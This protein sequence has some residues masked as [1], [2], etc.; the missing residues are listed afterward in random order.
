M[1]FGFLALQARQGYVDQLRAHGRFQPT[2]ATIVRSKLECSLGAQSSIPGASPGV[3]CG[4]LVQYR[5]EI[6]GQTHLSTRIAFV[7]HNESPDRILSRYP[8]GARVTAFVDPK[9]PNRA[10]LDNTAWSAM[11]V[12][13]LFLPF[14]LV[15]LG[16]IWVRQRLRAYVKKRTATV[17]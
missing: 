16:W 1:L 5:Y 6:D 15:G 13:R 8:L 10:V 7:A 14:L 2:G 9:D 4:P 12:I 11:Q 17:E 3:A